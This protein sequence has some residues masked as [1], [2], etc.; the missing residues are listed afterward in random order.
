[1]RKKLIWGLLSFS[2]MVLIISV[3]TPDLNAK[4]VKAGGLNIGQ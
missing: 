3:A 2:V 1:M 4:P